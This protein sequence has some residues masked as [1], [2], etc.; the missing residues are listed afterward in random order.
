MKS[1]KNTNKRE[2]TYR[3]IKNKSKRILEWK[4]TVNELKDKKRKHR[5]KATEIHPQ[6]RMDQAEK[7]A[8]IM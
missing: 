5:K 2:L 3:D 7:I 6:G 8:Y 1:E 4:S